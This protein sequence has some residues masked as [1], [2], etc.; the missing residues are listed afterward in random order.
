MRVNGVYMSAD[1]RQRITV[2]NYL[3]VDT[4]CLTGNNSGNSFCKKI[5]NFQIDEWDLILGQLVIFFN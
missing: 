3:P 4:D 2:C 5:K 1:A